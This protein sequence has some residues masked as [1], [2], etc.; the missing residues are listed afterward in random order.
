MSVEEE[1]AE[2][3]FVIADYRERCAA[4]VQLVKEYDA[5]LA[6][7]APFTHKDGRVPQELRQRARDEAIEMPEPG[8]VS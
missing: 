2:V 5:Y 8:G 7:I 3:S 1:L 4:L 6:Q